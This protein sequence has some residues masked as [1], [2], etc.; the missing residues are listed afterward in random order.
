MCVVKDFYINIQ[1]FQLGLT[2][3]PPYFK[4]ESKITCDFVAQ[5]SMFTYK[6]YS[7]V[8][9]RALS[10]DIWPVPSIGCIIGYAC[11]KTTVVCS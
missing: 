8:K 3:G 11:V 10:L 5:W 1:R 4:V 9:Q 7:I 2:Q 6:V